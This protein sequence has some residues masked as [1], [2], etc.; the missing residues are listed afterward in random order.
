MPIG[1]KSVTKGSLLCGRGHYPLAINENRDW[2]VVASEKGGD[3]RKVN[4]YIL[5]V[6]E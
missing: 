1:I 5:K 3:L 2:Q 6:F 4:R